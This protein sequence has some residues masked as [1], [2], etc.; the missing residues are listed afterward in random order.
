MRSYGY[1][2]KRLQHIRY[3]SGRKFSTLC[4]RIWLPM[5]HKN[6]AICMSHVFLFPSVIEL[7]I[8]YILCDCSF[9][10]QKNL[11]ICFMYA[12]LMCNWTLKFYIIAKLKACQTKKVCTNSM[13]LYNCK[14]LN[15]LYSSLIVAL[16][17]KKG[18]GGRAWKCWADVA[19]D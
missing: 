14:Q 11:L 17:K 15:N 10:L 9:V 13:L 16:A 4:M 1:P 2:R 8:H 18:G 3:F 6:F 12:C 7:Y 5:L 19:E